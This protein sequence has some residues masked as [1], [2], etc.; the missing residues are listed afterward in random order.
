MFDL[1]YGDHESASYVC[2]L[3]HCCTIPPLYSDYGQCGGTVCV[4]CGVRVY[5]LNVPVEMRSW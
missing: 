2:D 3:V 4:V 5:D 1:I